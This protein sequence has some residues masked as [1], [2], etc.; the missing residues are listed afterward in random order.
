MMN[1][2][3]IASLN[4]EEFNSLGLIN[5]QKIFLKKSNIKYLHKETFKNLKILIE[6]DLSENLI[7]QLDKQIFSGNDRLRILYLYSNPIKA[8]LPEQFPLLSH[9]RTIDLHDCLI[10]SIDSTSFS[11]VE[12]LEYLNFESNKLQSLPHNV[13]THMKNLKTL[14]LDENPWNCDCKLKNFRNWYVKT[15]LNRISLL[16]KA[17]QSLIDQSW[18][19]IGESEF[20]CAPTLEIFKGDFETSSNDAGAAADSNITF[21]C[22]TIGDPRPFIGWQFNGKV[23]ESGEENVVIESDELVGQQQQQHATVVI[24]SNDYTNKIWSNLSIYNITNANAGMYTCASHNSFGEASHNI[25]LNFPE[26]GTIEHVGFVKNSETFWYF[27]LLIGVFVTIIGLLLLSIICFMCRRVVRSGKIKNNI[28]GSISF[29]DQ[30]KKL[31]DLSITTTT[32]RTDKDGEQLNTP[33]TT[34][35]IRHHKSDSSIIALEPVHITMENF[36]HTSN[37]QNHLHYHR[38]ISDEIPLNISIFPPPPPEFCC[39][40]SSTGSSAAA[41]QQQQS[42]LANLSTNGQLF[43]PSYS[44]AMAAACAAAA[45]AASTVNGNHANVIHNNPKLLYEA[46]ASP[47]PPLLPPSSSSGMIGPHAMSLTNEPSSVNEA[48]MFPD[49]LNIMPNRLKI[50][51]TTTNL[52]S[53]TSSS[54]SPSQQMVPINLETYVT[55]PKKQQHLK[56]ISSMSSCCSSPCAGGATLQRPKQQQQQHNYTEFVHHSPEQQQ[57]Q[58][59]PVSILKQTQKNYD[60]N[61]MI[62]D[63]CFAAAANNRNGNDANVIGSSSSKCCACALK[64][65]NMGLRTTISGNIDSITNLDE[66][67]HHF[68]L[69]NENSTATYGNR[70]EMS[71]ASET[72]PPPPPPLSSALPA[73]DNHRR[74]GGGGRLSCQSYQQQQARFTSSPSQSPLKQ[75]QQQHSESSSAAHLMPSNDFVPL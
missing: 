31:L 43:H 15:K 4:R 23:I 35:S 30:E 65:D 13:F 39:P 14:L 59:Q 71:D 7:E 17:P 57:Q 33:S 29:N 55:L 62:S 49:L 26:R 54:S 44:A 69:S 9:L 70:E 60:K 27:G 8:L 5:L 37:L 64:S 6:L 21:K 53:I 61:M 18:E 51:S 38:R 24:S 34:T 11:N 36:H 74:A 72:L 32:E 73:E 12:A 56:T 1:E 46:A 66:Q 67:Q 52:S 2:N 47:P 41:Q 68:H 22:F 58:Q 48:S 42:S 16:C 75:Q 28:K 10:S 45:S 3:D 50:S 25:S 63:E 19:E 40:L 20:G